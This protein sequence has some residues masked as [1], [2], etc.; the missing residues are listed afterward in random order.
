M[1][2]MPLHLMQLSNDHICIVNQYCKYY[3]LKDENQDFFQT[4]IQSLHSLF[5]NKSF[6][7]PPNLLVHMHNQGDRI[8]NNALHLY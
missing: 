8:N 3:Y 1:L 6:V 5:L 7:F 2:S 4:L